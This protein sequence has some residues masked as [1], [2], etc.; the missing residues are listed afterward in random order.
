MNTHDDIPLINIPPNAKLSDFDKLLFIGLHSKVSDIFMQPDRPVTVRYRQRLI[1]AS[2]NPVSMETMKALINAM[3]STTQAAAI[4]AGEPQSW[5]HNIQIDGEKGLGE[6]TK[7]LRFRCNSKS[8]Q[9]YRSAENRAIVMRPT[10]QLP[11]KLES[12]NLPPGLTEALFP[13]SGIVLFSGPTGSGKTTT[14]AAT[15]REQCYD[16]DGKVIVTVEEPVEYNLHALPD[17]TAFITHCEVGRN[18]A[19]FNLAMRAALRENPDV[20]MTGEMRDEESMLMAI[21]ASQTGHT[22]YSTLHTN[23]VTS[24]F[25]RVSQK[26]PPDRAESVVATFIEASRTFVYQRLF[27]SNKGG[28]VAVVEWVSLSVMDRIALLTA[29]SD[30]GISAVTRKMNEIMD[31]SGLWYKDSARA[32]YESGHLSSTAYESIVRTHE[33]E[34]K[35]EHAD[36]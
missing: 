14:L 31:H 8:V 15:L 22:V 1:R 13:E 28:V 5:S 4:D 27:P 26:M 24:V 3:V 19:D 33:L 10:P 23:S 16:P 29:L 12:L 7:S 36:G 25:V 32:A 17:V 21:E 18:V 35:L 30:G 6:H 20:I 11:M 2:K 34:T 9:T